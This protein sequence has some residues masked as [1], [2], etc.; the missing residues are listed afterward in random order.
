M[1][2][3]LGSI[4][5]TGE[6][7]IEVPFMLGDKRCYPDGLIRVSRGVRSWTALVEAKTGKNDPQP[8]SYGTHRTTHEVCTMKLKSTAL[9]QEQRVF[10]HGF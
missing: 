9:L 2:A 1:L 6:T 4:S 7:F 8:M 5:G 10:E 3:P